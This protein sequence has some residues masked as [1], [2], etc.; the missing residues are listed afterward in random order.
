MLKLS[1]AALV[2]SCLVGAA[3][4][5]TVAPESLSLEDIAARAAKPLPRDEVIKL[6][7]GARVNWAAFAGGERIWT[8][9]P[10]GSLIGTRIGTGV[11]SF[12]PHRKSGRGQWSVRDDGSYCANIDYGMMMTEGWCWQFFS[13][14][15]HLMMHVTPATTDANSAKITFSH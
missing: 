6:V 5:Q 12:N 9:E 15:D 8:N 13:L 4:A 11:G 3:H 14:G 2:C 10:D 1:C 7:S